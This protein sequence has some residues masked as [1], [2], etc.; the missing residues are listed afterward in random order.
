MFKKIHR[1][2]QGH[3]HQKYHGKY[4]HAKQL[5]IFDIALL[6]FALLLVASSIFFTLWQPYVRENISLSTTLNTKPKSGEMTKISV[7]F[8]NN[9]KFTLSSATLAIHL[10]SGFIV[11]RTQTPFSYFSKNSIIKLSD[12]EPGAQGSAEIYGRFWSEPKRETTITSLLT[13][14]P[15]N[16]SEPEQKIIT[17]PLTLSESVLQTNFSVETSTFPNQKLPFTYSVT[18]QSNQSIKNIKSQIFKENKVREKIIEND[19]NLIAGETKKITGTIEVGSTDLNEFLTADT[20]IKL[21]D[22]TEVVQSS[23]SRKITILYPNVELTTSLSTSTTYA[24]PNDVLQIS[25][26]LKNKSN[27]YFDNAKIKLNFSAEQETVIDI[28]KTARENGFKIQNNQLVIDSSAQKFLKRVAP[29]STN[30]FVINLS[31]LKNFKLP[32]KSRVNLLVTP[33]FVSSALPLYSQTLE[34]KGSETKIP[35]AGLVTFQIEPRYFTVDNNQVGRGPLPPQVGKTTKYWIFATL[36]NTTNNL[37][38]AS[39]SAN[40][41]SGVELTGKQIVDLGTLEKQDNKITWHA[42]N[43]PEQNEL[44]IYFEIAL[45]PTVKQ[46]GEVLQLISDIIFRSTDD[47]TNEQLTINTFETISTLLNNN[48]RGSLYSAK[49]SP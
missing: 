27:T 17:T 10:P 34:I 9:T 15:A 44:H 29:N 11:D 41:P 2:F 20:R 25:I 45:L 36:K 35:L 22:Q 39:F 48:D 47:F 30:A 19:F 40:I 18:N 8:S 13:Y 31:F 43:I 46:K 1:A 5:F 4:R 33:Y 24:K 12:L 32:N 28:Q 16:K 37:K 26:N 3:Y 38:S 14:K 23:D 42:E 6:I 7:S 49:V 21:D